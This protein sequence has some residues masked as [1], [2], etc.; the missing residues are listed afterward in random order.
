MPQ[1]TASTARL[2]ARRRAASSAEDPDSA[3]GSAAGAGATAAGDCRRWHPSAAAINEAVQRV[4]ILEAI[5]ISPPSAL[6]RRYLLLRLVGFGLGVEHQA[7]GDVVL[8]DIADVGRRLGA[9]LL[10]D[11]D[12]DVVE[13]LVR[14]EPLLRGGLSRL[15]DI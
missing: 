12:L 15:R 10:R 5:A 7:V 2:R 8:V 3:V 1:M 13:P 9:N 11:D 4:A 14:V 6:R